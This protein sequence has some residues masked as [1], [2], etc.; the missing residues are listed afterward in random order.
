MLTRTIR[1]TGE[2]LPEVED[3]EPVDEL[4]LSDEKV[5]A[6][7]AENMPNGANRI[8]GGS[9]EV[10]QMCGEDDIPPKNDCCDE[11][12]DRRL[13]KAIREASPSRPKSQVV[14]QSGGLQKQWRATGGISTQMGSPEIATPQDRNKPTSLPGTK[15]MDLSSGVQEESWV[16]GEPLKSMAI[17]MTENTFAALAPE[18]A[19][20]R[21]EDQP[22]HSPSNRLGCRKKKNRRPETASQE[23]FPTLPGGPVV[24][25]PDTPK[26]KILTITAAAAKKQEKVIVVGAA[27]KPVGRVKALKASNDAKSVPKPAS[28]EVKV[29]ADV[30]K[31]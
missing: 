1:A 17:P 30:L 19:A 24:R 14:D 29:W 5:D 20:P 11:R 23:D 4:P 12:D 25:T 9:K 3:D 27:T 28:R 7:S 2:K 13:S 18:I 16:A 31:K 15:T 22:E 6:L 8:D 26:I 10:H 21:D